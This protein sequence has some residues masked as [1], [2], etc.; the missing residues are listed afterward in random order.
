MTGSNSDKF[1]AEDVGPPARR[2]WII[3]DRAAGP[4]GSTRGW[5]FVFDEMGA[6]GDWGVGLDNWEEWFFEILRYPS[7]YASQPLIWR[8]EAD[9][10]VVDLESLQA[11]YDGKRALADQTPEE[12]GLKSSAEDR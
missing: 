5:A 4:P 9:G 12:A 2:F 3:R 10:E 6:D 1:I 8:R 11:G 7:C